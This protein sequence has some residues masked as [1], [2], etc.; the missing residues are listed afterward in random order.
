[1]IMLSAIA[2]HTERAAKFSKELRARQT[3]CE[4]KLWKKLRAGRFHDYK[5]RR[6]VPLG[7]FIVDFLCVEARLIIEIDGDSHWQYGAQKYDRD[8]QKYLETK[9]FYFLRFGNREV[10][11]EIDLVLSC[12]RERLEGTSLREDFHDPSP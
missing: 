7:P 3:R 12:I 10:L 9:G 1:M 4:R 5:F 2:P 6:Q 11:Y 8:R